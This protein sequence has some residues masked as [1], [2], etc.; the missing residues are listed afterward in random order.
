MV[1]ASA[2]AGPKVATILVLRT[3][4]SLAAGKRSG[5]SVAGIGTKKA[6]HTLEL[7]TGLIFTDIP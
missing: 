5:T 2:L 3:S 1:L 4:I 7:L 6:N